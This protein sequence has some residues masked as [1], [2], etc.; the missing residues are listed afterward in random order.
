MGF[1]AALVTGATSGIGEAIARALPSTTALWLTGR[2][3]D[4]LGALATE[5]AVGARPVATLA[6]DLTGAAGQA[7][8]I[9]WARAAPIDLLVNNAGFGRFGPALEA[10]ERDRA[11]V[12]VNLL[13]PMALAQALMPGMLERA[14]ASGRRAGLINVSSLVGFFPWPYFAT[15]SATKAYLVA[16]SQALAAELAGEPIDV[17]ALCPGSTETRFHE[18]AGYMGSASWGSHAADRVAR[19]GL[20]ALGRRPVHV[21]GKTNRIIVAAMRFLPRRLTLPL[22]ARVTARS[23]QRRS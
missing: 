14:R 7:A 1:E 13:A 9:A 22:A 21:V 12:E 2:D 16:W 10:G 8:L 4:R 3:R 20:A 6:A 11:M 17:L 15:Y 5:L 18:R 23:Y 19:E